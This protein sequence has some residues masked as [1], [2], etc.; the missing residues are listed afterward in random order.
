LLGKKIIDCYK[1][2]TCEVKYECFGENKVINS[3]AIDF[4]EP[5]ISN[6]SVLMDYCIDDTHAMLATTDKIAHRKKW[7]EMLEGCDE[8]DGCD[9]DYYQIVV[10][11]KEV[12]CKDYGDDFI[13][14]NGAC[15]RN[16]YDDSCRT[17]GEGTTH[18]V[19]ECDNGNWEAYSGFVCSS[20]ELW[21]LY[22]YC[23]HPPHAFGSPFSVF[24]I[25]GSPEF[26][27]LLTVTEW[28]CRIDEI[29][30]FDF[31]EDVY[32][33]Y[34]V[35]FEEGNYDDQCWQENMSLFTS[36]PNYPHFYK[37]AEDVP[38][39][40][41]DWDSLFYG[42]D[43]GKEYPAEPYSHTFD[44]TIDPM[45]V[46]P[47]TFPYDITFGCD[48]VPMG[49]R[50]KDGDI[51]KTCSPLSVVSDIDGSF[52]K[53]AYYDQE[54]A[55]SYPDVDPIVRIKGFRWESL[56][57]CD[58]KVVSDTTSAW[59][60]YSDDFKLTKVFLKYCNQSPNGYPLCGVLGEIAYST[61]TNINDPQLLIC[62]LDSH[63]CRI[64][65]KFDGELSERDKHLSMC[66]YKGQ[67]ICSGRTV[68][69]CDDKD[70]DGK[71][72]WYAEPCPPSLECVDGKCVCENCCYD[73]CFFGSMKCENGV[74]WR[75]EYGENGCTH[76]VS[77]QTCSIGDVKC[78]DKQICECVS[79][80]G[81]PIWN[82]TKLSN[83]T[84][85]DKW[86][87]G[88]VLKECKEISKGSCSGTY[89]DEKA[90]SDCC[91]DEGNGNAYCG[92]HECEYGNQTSCDANGKKK[93]CDVNEHGCYYWKTIDCCSDE[94]T[95]DGSYP[96][97]IDTCISQTCELGDDGC[98]HLV[99]TD[100]CSMPTG[101]NEHWTC[102]SETGQCG[103]CIDECVEGEEMKANG[104]CYKCGDWDGDSCTEWK[105]VKC[106]D[107]CVDSCACGA[108]SCYDEDTIERCDVGADGC[109]HLNYTDCPPGQVC[110]DGQCVCKD[111]CNLGDK[112]CKPGSPCIMQKCEVVDGCRKWVDYECGPCERCNGG[113]CISVCDVIANPIPIPL[114]R[115]HR[116]ETINVSTNIN[117]TRR[118]NW[119]NLYISALFNSILVNTSSSNLS[120][121]L[122]QIGPISLQ[123]TSLWIG[124]Y[125]V[126]VGNYLPLQILLVANND[127][128]AGLYIVSIY[129]NYTCV[130][131]ETKCG[132]VT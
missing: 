93:I 22:I 27:S 128:P 81:C 115:M 5:I 104:K 119:P 56:A 59:C 21:P 98:Y 34:D 88:L 14:R 3:H 24:E 101:S 4:S 94:C 52:R 127:I 41:M 70:G 100:C 121:Y 132:E 111:E 53:I 73:E 40:C 97:C 112:R 25:M 26:P 64:W 95:P 50:K 1:N 75:C 72:E 46:Y 120:A 28:P 105:E 125:P 102:N 48:G 92:T 91:V 99:E 60:D 122:T 82:C 107:S 31:S 8:K 32:K 84:V 45:T 117:V 68:L 74:A 11:Y 17:P 44:R 16:T 47:T 80:H 129:G 108:I 76:W 126:F 55:Y 96:K 69:Y 19:S 51:V 39:Q 35:A 6:K 130:C 10:N 13:C 61:D 9:V 37:G 18:S 12:N 116:G 65:K 30:T 103:G 63:G 118:F 43:L 83:C 20:W 113:S 124:E 62:G 38:M 15:I 49:Y 58:G 77:M 89:I 42:G 7:K 29:P 33:C 23:E 85:G 110:K 87:D 106:N 123:P 131:N 57:T 78:D 79:Y 67:R 114:Q 66:S 54:K 36:I 2:C 90:C 109:C 71:L 86:C